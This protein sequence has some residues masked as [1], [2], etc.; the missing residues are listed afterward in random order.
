MLSGERLR[1]LLPAGGPGEQLYYY[2]SIGSTNDRAKELAAAGCPDSTVVVA[3]EQTAG[4]GRAGRGWLTPAG[5]ALAV[6]LVLRPESLSAEDLVGWTAV[7]ALSVREALQRL[8]A[9][10]E[11]KWPND[12][13]LARRKVAGVLTEA[14]WDG[15]RVSSL[16]VGIGVNVRADSV[17][18]PRTLDYP[19]ISVEAAVDRAVDRAELLVDILSALGRWAEG[20]RLARV[21][22]AWETALAFRGETVHVEGL[23]RAWQGRL[24]GLGPRGELRLRLDNGDSLLLPVEAMNLR[25]VDSGPV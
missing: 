3:D 9:S 12:V 7:G 18:G 11:I 25:P 15:D 10:C 13:L 21:L 24:S 6:S 19:A 5:A 8:G 14:A 20:Y 22:A 2:A 16:V 17:P 23:G 1:A 4:R